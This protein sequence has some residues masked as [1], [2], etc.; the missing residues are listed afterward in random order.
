MSE[1]KHYFIHCDHRPPCANY[2]MGEVNQSPSQMR[3]SK[4]MKEWTSR[5]RPPSPSQAE[6]GIFPTDRQDFCPVHAEDAK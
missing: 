6:V 2:I 3:R 5:T 1:T 4:A